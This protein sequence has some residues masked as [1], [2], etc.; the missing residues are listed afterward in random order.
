MFAV[1]PKYFY[2]PNGKVENAVHPENMRR[3][4]DPMRRHENYKPVIRPDS[5]VPKGE[6]WKSGPHPPQKE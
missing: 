1:G 6:P 2:G 4:L 3:D 5:M